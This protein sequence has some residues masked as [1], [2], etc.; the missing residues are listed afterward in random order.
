MKKIITFL[1]LLSVFT[2]S[3]KAQDDS[4]TTVPKIKVESTE[5]EVE[6]GYKPCFT[7][8]SDAQIKPTVTV[9]DSNIAIY[10]NYSIYNSEMD[11]YPYRTDIWFNANK[12]GTTKVHITF[13]DYPELNFDITI[14]IIIPQLE[15]IS[16]DTELEIPVGLSNIANL[17]ANIAI[18]DYNITI[19]D[20][21]ISEFM[22]LTNSWHSQGKRNN[23]QFFGLKEGE[24]TAHVAFTYFPELNYDI[25]IKVVKSDYNPEFRHPLGKTISV[26]PGENGYYRFFSNFDFKGTK[27]NVRIDDED[28]AA[29]RYCNYKSNTN[30][31][32]LMLY[33]VRNGRT[34]AHIEFDF[35]PE[36]NFDLEINVE[37]PE[38]KIID[39]VKEV[40][41]EGFFEI[42][43]KTNYSLEN[44][45]KP[46]ITSEKGCI[47]EYAQMFSEFNEDGTYSNNF[48]LK[49]T[50]K[51]EDVLNFKFLKYPQLN[52]SINVS[53]I[54][55]EL[56]L[57]KEELSAPLNKT[58]DFKLY[59]NVLLPKYNYQIISDNDEIARYYDWNNAADNETAEE[60]EY[61]LQFKTGSEGTANITIK[62]EDFPESTISFKIIVENVK[63]KGIH[64]SMKE[65]NLHPGEFTYLSIRTEPQRYELRVKA[66]DYKEKKVIELVKG[67]SHSS[68]YSNTV[69]YKVLALEEGKRNL[70]FYVYEYPDVVLN[71]PVNITPREA[72]VADHILFSTHES[73]K[74]TKLS[75]SEHESGCHSNI[76]WMSSDPTV[77]EVD[78]DGVVT[79]KSAGSAVITAVCSNHTTMHGILVDTETALEDVVS[80]SIN[81]YTLG[82]TIIVN[83][84]VEGEKANVYTA[85]GAL[86]MTVKADGSILRLPVNAKGAYIVKAGKSAFKVVL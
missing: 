82:T 17:V 43:L 25:K 1:M 61:W 36:L 56:R 71:I 52:F 38:L 18:S 15:I 78:T 7:Y 67:D 84:L 19:E 5:I 45:G 4:G 2:G 9:E 76:E 27:F 28:I 57:D 37:K 59:S 80:R 22:S 83:G 12:P 6:K 23:L 54:V 32:E 10:T 70:Q 8:F 48:S 66:Q 47:T 85:D 26:E 62:F 74:T 33:G 64:S 79:T 58:V 46:I 42:I 11:E 68:N 34:V 24:T 77:A 44:L 73:G 86:L 50:G 29:F 41:V 21:S 72:V 20:T 60:K 55:P 63:A 51:G 35:F 39:P 31:V 30:V 40:K 49:F 65:I 53:T 75:I 69:I 3:V 14:K 13:E 81:V 16:K